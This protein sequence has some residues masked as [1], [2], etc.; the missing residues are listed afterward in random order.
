MS[1]LTPNAQN[2]MDKRILIDA[3]NVNITI[4]GGGTFATQGYIEALLALLPG[5]IDVLHPAEAYI[6]D[7]RYHTIDVPSRSKAQQYV[8]L[9]KGQF[10][11]AGQF[12]I[13]YLHQHPGN[14]EYVLISTGL[15]AGGIIPKLKDLPIKT[16]V[17]HHNYEPEYRMDSRS[18]LTLRGKT[19]ILVRKWERRGYR[20]ADINLFLTR[21]D[22]LR[23]EKEYG[24]HPNNHVT[25]VFE[26][27]GEEQPIANGPLTDSAVITCALGDIQNQA[28]LL[29]FADT[30]LPIFEQVLP[31]WHIELMG[32]NPLPAITQMASHHKC[33]HLTP[34]PEDIRTLAAKSKIYLCPMDAGGGLKLRIMD[35]LR[36]GQP[37]LVHERSARGYDDFF[38]MPFF[39]TYHDIESFRNG[40]TQISDYVQSDTYSREAVQSHY[41]QYFGLEAGIQ[42]LK[43]ILCK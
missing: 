18:I 22:C 27:T 10:H 26:P 23:F 36:A 11:R 15:Y 30:Y 16:I 3:T 24:E 25:G 14:Y 28:S 32:R 35:G 12:I 21:Q 42:R 40:L 13:D 2:R 34:N 31:N 41:Y 38:N 17:L 8:G 33:I 29:R 7:A 4:P 19:D 9:L 5:Q 20:N 39:Y 6:R 1:G 43:A 37:V